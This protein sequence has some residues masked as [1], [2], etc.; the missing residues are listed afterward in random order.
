MEF[1]EATLTIH[2]IRQIFRKLNLEPK[3]VGSLPP[4]LNPRK[5]TQPLV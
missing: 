3:I 2:E 4:E 1:D 5:K